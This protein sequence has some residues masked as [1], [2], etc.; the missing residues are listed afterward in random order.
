MPSA[1]VGE[2]FYSPAQLARQW[3]RQL[4]VVR[5][6]ISEG[7]LATDERGLVS[8]SSLRDFYRTYGNPVQ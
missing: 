7:K 6:M 1:P 5:Q 2:T 8:N 4:S 3:E